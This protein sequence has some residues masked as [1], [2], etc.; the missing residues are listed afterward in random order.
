[1]IVPHYHTINRTEWGT[2]DK[3]LLN[4]TKES[5]EKLEKK[6][7]K[8]C[9]ISY[10]HAMEHD[11]NNL[12]GKVKNDIKLLNYD[13]SFESEE[14]CLNFYLKRIFLKKYAKSFRT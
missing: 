14:E 6:M 9:N 2:I 5:L 7:L 11:L 4:V 3:E 8:V 1:M 10:S 13:S 12:I